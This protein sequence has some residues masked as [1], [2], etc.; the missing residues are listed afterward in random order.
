M[1]QTLEQIHEQE[2]AD[3]ERRYM[4]E[5]SEMKETLEAEIARVKKQHDETDKLYQQALEEALMEERAK[6]ALDASTREEQIK[7]DMKKT[8]QAT[9][10]KLTDLLDVAKAEINDQFSEIKRAENEI[11]RLNVEIDKLQVE[12]A[13]TRESPRV[14]ELIRECETYKQRLIELETELASYRQNG[15][16]PPQ[17]RHSGEVERDAAENLNDKTASGQVREKTELHT[18]AMVRSPMLLQRPF[19]PLSSP[20]STPEL[21]F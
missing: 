3:L 7:A 6:L 21:S 2:R 16:A 8:E 17:Y 20:S 5:H 13:G 19:S 14:A 4:E 1:E 15:G 12:I 11:D 10:S 9:V 18:A